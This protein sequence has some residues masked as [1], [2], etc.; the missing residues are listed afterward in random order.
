MANADPVL[1]ATPRHQGSGNWTLSGAFKSELANE[2]VPMVI[3]DVEKHDTLSFD[4]MLKFILEKVDKNKSISSDERLQNT[5][6]A[7]LGLCANEGLHS[8]LDQYCA[9]MSDKHERHEPF[10]CALNEALANL[11]NVNVKQSDFR[12]ASELDILFCRNADHEIHGFHLGAADNRPLETKRKPGVVLTSTP[13]TSRVFN[14]DWRERSVQRLVQLPS[15]DLSW[16]DVLSAWEFKLHSKEV[17]APPPSY[18]TSL[19]DEYETMDVHSRIKPKMRDPGRKDLQRK[20]AQG[21]KKSTCSDTLLSKASLNQARKADDALETQPEDPPADAVRSDR[22]PPGVQCAMHGA[23]ILSRA[24]A[25]SHAL[26]ML[27]QDSIFRIWWYDHQGAIQ[28]TGIDF[29]KDLPRFLALLFALQRFELEDWGRVPEFDLGEQVL[30]QEGLSGDPASTKITNRM[31]RE[32]EVDTATHVYKTL[33]FEGRGTHVV[34]TKCHKVA[35]DHP[36]DD[37]PPVVTNLLWADCTGLSEGE[38]VQC[39]AKCAGVEQKIEDHTPQVMDEHQYDE[40]NTGTVRQKLGIPLK[41]HP[42]GTER[43]A[44]RVSRVITMG[45]LE[46]LC[47]LT[48]KAFVNGWFQLT[49]AHCLNWGKGVQHKDISLNSLLYYRKPDKTPCAIL[50]DWDPQVPSSRRHAEASN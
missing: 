43:R 30:M 36:P 25:V 45:R 4:D 33:G 48:G 14:I 7:L 22:P 47:R 49:R 38:V 28:T 17:E 5:L 20:G 44:Y 3:H 46:L 15:G 35:N 19:H 12:P 2:A 13:A 34:E 10:V 18:G 31:D 23:E 29:L 9:E 32:V 40:H 41:V 21:A 42:D 8:L 6:Q 27:I 37:T 16:H 26:V 11:K 39:A 1:N 24:P 50:I